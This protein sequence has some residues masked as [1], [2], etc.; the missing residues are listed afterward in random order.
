MVDRLKVEAE[1]LGRLLKQLHDS[2]DDLRKAL[3]A[4]ED[5]GPKSTGSVELDHACDEFHDSWDDVIGKIADGTG[6]IEDK[7]RA[8][9]ND[10]AATD[11]AI[12]A[13][14]AAE[15]KR[16]APPTSPGPPGLPNGFRWKGTP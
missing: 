14:F 11:E 13:A 1:S 12:R 2:Q 5:I 4:M 7:L 10:F 8:T 6:A 3:S 9:K 16:Q 15:A